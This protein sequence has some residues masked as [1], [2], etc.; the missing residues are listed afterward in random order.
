MHFGKC[1]TYLTAMRSG[2]TAHP[3]AFEEGD[4]CRR[5]PGK[6]PDHGTILAMDRQRARST[7]L[8]QV[9]H[10]PE[11][12]RQVRLFNPALVEGQD[13]GA[14]RCMQQ[15]VGVLRSLGDTL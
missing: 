12:E 4:Q 6:L 11:K 9:L 1:S 10:Q 8:R 3:H 15:V 14:I 13:E 5:P 2:R 7:L